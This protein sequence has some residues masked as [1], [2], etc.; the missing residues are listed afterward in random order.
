MALNTPDRA[1]ELM[2]E[3]YIN[4]CYVAM[5]NSEISFQ[6]TYSSIFNKIEGVPADTPNRLLNNVC[7]VV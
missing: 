6:S 3:R 5:N 7:W 4:N 1:V 2:F